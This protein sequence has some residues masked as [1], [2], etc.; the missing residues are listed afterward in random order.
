[1]HLNALIVQA[2]TLLMP[3]DALI[4]PADA[5]TMPAYAL[6]LQVIAKFNLLRIN[7]MLY[8]GDRYHQLLKSYLSQPKSFSPKSDAWV[9]LRLR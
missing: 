2:Y 6:A 1:M 5:L 7:E 3:A 9:G 8:L 4:M